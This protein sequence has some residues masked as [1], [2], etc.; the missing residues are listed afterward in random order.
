M[1]PDW[2]KIFTATQLQRVEML[3]VI[4]AQNEIQ[5]VIINKQDSL[6][7]LGDIQLFVNRNDVLRALQIINK[8]VDE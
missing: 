8:S 6:Y 7:K 1:N 2:Q 5:S 4:L 3:K